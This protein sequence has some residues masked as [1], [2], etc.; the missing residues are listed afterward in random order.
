MYYKNLL[1][2]PVCLFLVAS[3][4]L[5]KATPAVVT[6]IAVTQTATTLPPLP[7][8]ELGQPE[9]PLILVLPPSAT[10]PE[11]INAAKTIAAQFTQ[12][13][14]YTVVVVQMSSQAEI[15]TT[16]EQGNA[17][18]VLLD[19]LTYALAYQ[20]NLAL[21]A[22]AKVQDDKITYGAQFIASRN[23]GFKSYFDAAS[24]TNTAEASTALKQ[25]MD[26]KPCW[27]EETSPS[28]YLVPFGILKDQLI[29][30]QPAAFVQ[31]HPAVVRSIY[32][33]G[34]CDFGATYIDARK[35]PSLEDQYPDL[36]EQ[37]LVIWQIPKIIPYDVLAF[38]T[39][40]PEE[41]QEQFTTMI[42]SIFQ[43]TDGKDAFLIAFDIDEL[44][45][46]SNA[47]FGEFHK[48][49]EQTYLDLSILLQ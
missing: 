47:D 23:S 44:R 17:D 3:C 31:G 9:N 21:A 18:I 37:V 42:Q 12:R 48:Y 45:L 38:S 14:G 19:P 1:T 32:A 15:I 35:F 26:K 25:F 13:S 20:K 33:G 40:M 39:R 7:T 6:E 46:V 29:N 2:I 28:G 5:P 34:I 8:P 43:T 30:T 41:M 16:L 11:Q 10:T 27:T 49:M 22:F 4:S 36:M 24:Q